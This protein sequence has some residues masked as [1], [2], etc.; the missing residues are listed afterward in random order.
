MT[1][2]TVYIVL[3]M[4]EDC[5]ILMASAVEV[6]DDIFASFFQFKFMCL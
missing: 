3:E 2:Y 4:P 6:F 5:L 1:Y